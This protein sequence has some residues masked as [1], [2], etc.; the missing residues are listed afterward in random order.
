MA[1]PLVGRRTGSRR[2]TSVGT[3]SAPKICC[4]CASSNAARKASRPSYCAS[5]YNATILRVHLGVALAADLTDIVG[6]HDRQADQPVAVDHH[7][8]PWF[9]GEHRLEMLRH[10]HAGIACAIRRWSVRSWPLLIASEVLVAQQRKPRVAC[11]ALSRSRS[12][13]LPTASRRRTG[14]SACDTCVAA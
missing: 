12:A 3:Y 2:V 7:P 13:L 1:V 9:V 11:T 10:N 8:R 4:A 6:G 5:W 14:R